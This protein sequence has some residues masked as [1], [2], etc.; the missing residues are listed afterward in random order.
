MNKPDKEPGGRRSGF[1]KALSA[2][3]AAEYCQGRFDTSRRMRRLDRIER[4]FAADLMALVGPEA[5]IQDAPGG[6]GR[7]F[8]IFRAARSLTMLDFNQTM[9]DEA[10]AKAAGAP[11]VTLLQGDCANL[12]FEPGSF[13]L[14]FCMRLFHHLVD[15][16]L[17]LTVL[18]E[19]ARVSRRYVALSFYD[20]Y[21]WRYLRRA[22]LGKRP[23]GHSVALGRMVA[24]ARQAGGLRLVRKVPAVRWIEQQRMLLFEKG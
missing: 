8:D 3:G 2:E 5:A 4:G 17:R 23:S 7:F 16:A 14:C 11:G 21:C 24:L 20:C 13:D 6:S 1:R 18:G 15:D 10:A 12:P 19:L 9:V 22:I